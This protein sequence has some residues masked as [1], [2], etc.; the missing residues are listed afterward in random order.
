MKRLWILLFSLA[1]MV[2]TASFSYGGSMSLQDGW[3]SF[4]LPDGWEDMEPGRRDQLTQEYYNVS[5]ADLESDQGKEAELL[6]FKYKEFAGVPATVE[7]LYASDYYGQIDY[8]DC[9][10]EELAEYF[11][12]YGYELIESILPKGENDREISLDQQQL[13]TSESG[14]VFIQANVKVETETEKELQYRIYYTVKSSCVITV[15]LTCYGDEVP[16]QAEAEAEQMIMGF[17]DDGY[18]DL[19]TGNGEIFE[20]DEGLWDDDSSSGTG[21]IFLLLAIAPIAAAAWNFW[22]K[23]ADGPPAAARAF[24]EGSEGEEKREQAA[25]AEVSQPVSVPREPL[26]KENPKEKLS[27]FYPLKADG[28]VVQVRSKENLR[29]SGARAADESYLDSLKTLLDSGLLTKEQYREMI[30]KH[31]REH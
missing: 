10:Q 2:S 26:K 15:L 11:D 6:F 22:K 12:D 7:L 28:K 19:Y 18:Y 20:D 13:E 17:S 21:M 29:P 23:E 27:K 8:R 16:S 31:K 14:D 25:P 1:V 24:S 9:G 5:W 4:E 3:I 30:E